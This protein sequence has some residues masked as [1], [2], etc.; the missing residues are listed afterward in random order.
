MLGRTLIW[1]FHLQ[2]SVV[3]EGRERAVWL[4]DAGAEKFSVTRTTL[5][6]FLRASF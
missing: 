3:Q 4:G 2:V 5:G 1:R 6:H